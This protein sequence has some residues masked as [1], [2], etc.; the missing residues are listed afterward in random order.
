M[1]HH[2][3]ILLTF[4]VSNNAVDPFEKQFDDVDNWLYTMQAY[5]SSSPISQVA[6]KM[7]PIRWNEV[8]LAGYAIIDVWLHYH[9][10]L[11]N[12]G[13]KINA[14]IRCYD[15]ENATEMVACTAKYLPDDFMPC[16]D[17]EEVITL[18]LLSS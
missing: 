1:K 2:I 14:C 17:V 9:C 7:G 3:L 16:W 18:S 11:Q 15:T 4:I 8:G 10:K 5:L 6:G 12:S 13:E